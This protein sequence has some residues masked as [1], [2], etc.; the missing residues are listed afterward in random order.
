MHVFG[1][2]EENGG[3]SRRSSPC[4]TTVVPN[5]HIFQLS[6]ELLDSSMSHLKILVETVTLRDE[7]QRRSI[8]STSS[9]RQTKKKNVHAA[10]IA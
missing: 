7:L 8:V 10:P 3:K 6:L 1:W 5:L 4:A 2:E 9:T